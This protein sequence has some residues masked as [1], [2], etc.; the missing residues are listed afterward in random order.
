MD[1]VL[2]ENLSKRYGTF[3]ALRGVNLRVPAG[4]LFGFLGPNGAGK[5]TTIRI[6]LGLLRGTSGRARVLGSDAWSAGARVRAD[7][8]YL[9]GDVRFYDGL[10]GRA[11]LRFLDGVRGG[12]SRS[13]I[14]RLAAVFELPLDRRVRNYSRGMKQ[15]LGLIQAL[16]HKPRLLILDEP[17]TALDPLVRQTLF[18]ELRTVAADGRTVLFSSHTLAEVEELCDEVAI[19]RRG[20]LIEQNRVEVLRERAVRHVDVFLRE[21]RPPA[22]PLPDGLRVNHQS[23]G[24]LAC[25]WAGPVARLLDWLQ[26]TDVRDV[27]IAP[28]DLEDLFLAYYAD[29]RPEPRP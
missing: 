6:L 25:A 11:T 3:Q 16:M 9:A 7:V 24:H 17:T 28:P 2:T 5:T 12:R 15:K 18:H 23:D 4:S 13:E 22:A 1:A 26:R 19:V 29:D 21:G 10:T 20:E 8:G 14:E 27:I